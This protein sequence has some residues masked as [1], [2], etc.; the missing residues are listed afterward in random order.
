MNYDDIVYIIAF[1]TKWLSDFNYVKLKNGEWWATDHQE[2]Y[3][4]HYSKVSTP[5]KKEYI[6]EIEYEY[7]KDIVKRKL[8]E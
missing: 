6:T 1:D 3:L 4:P 2:G 7:Q 5:D 8:N